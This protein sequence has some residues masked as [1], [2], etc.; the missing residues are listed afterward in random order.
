MIDRPWVEWPRVAISMNPIRAWHQEHYGFC[1][2]ALVR[3]EPDGSTEQFSWRIRQADFNADETLR[4][5]IIGW[6]YQR[7]AVEYE[8]VAVTVADVA[9]GAL[10]VALNA[11]LGRKLMLLATRRAESRLRA[12]VDR[13]GCFLLRE[14]SRW[15]DLARW[16]RAAG[17]ETWGHAPTPTARAHG[18]LAAMDAWAERLGVDRAWTVPRLLDWQEV[19]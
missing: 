18:A 3:R 12:R 4:Y 14:R 7:E 6:D 1:D 8:E 10:P 11:T 16:K 5:S 15:V 13:T 9:R 17:V 2:L 19:L